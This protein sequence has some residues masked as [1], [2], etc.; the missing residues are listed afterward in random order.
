MKEF[1]AEAPP[2]ARVQRPWGAFNQFAHNEKVTV[3]LM[4]VS[5]DRR[6]SLQ[7]HADRAELWVILD[8]GAVVQVGDR[9]MRPSVGDE[10]WIPAGTRHRLGSA[11][12]AVRVLE[13]AFGDW[14]QGDIARFD[15][16]YDRPAE[17]EE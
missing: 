6:L 7:S 15:D 2:V 9:V 16:D 1:P 11:G 13:V 4:T 10:I 17:G 14:R 3:S 8:E 12:R 5:P